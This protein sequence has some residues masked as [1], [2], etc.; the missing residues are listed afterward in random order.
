[1]A[2]GDGRTLEM[3]TSMPEQMFSAP[4]QHMSLLQLDATLLIQ[5][6]LFLILLF[7]LDRILFKPILQSLRLR[8]EKVDGRKAEAIA[9]RAEAEELV[10]R[11]RSTL[12]E[13]RR[14]AS[15]IRDE[16]IAQGK[17][18]E[19]RL[20]DEVRQ[21]ARRELETAEQ[22]QEL[23]VAQAR[24]QI[25]LQV[26]GLAASIVRRVLQM[27]VL[28]LLLGA[29]S[30]AVAPRT[31]ADR[32]VPPAAAAEPAPAEVEPPA[33]H[34]A[35][36]DPAKAAAAATPQ[37]CWLDTESA[38]LGG[39]LL[40][41]VLLLWLL[42][43]F[44]RRPVRQMLTA[45][46]ERVVADLAEAAR[47]REEAVDLL[48]M[49]RAKLE[50]LEEERRD[51]LESFRRQGE[52]ERRRLIDE[53]EQQAER[54]RRDTVALI[55]QEAARARQKI[56]LELIDEALALAEK[57][58]QQQVSSEDDARQMDSFLELLSGS[59]REPSSPPPMVQL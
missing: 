49:A 25:P 10:S 18:H 41:F 48:A 56:Q 53:A 26:P 8:T 35:G 40:N 43:R 23:A 15:A 42:V 27:G 21:L 13:A 30:L 59:P 6:G 38:Q 20:I 29:A 46:R 54:I 32:L 28:L 3:T 50:G 52:L 51:L 2:I 57:Q 12:E 45:R 11:Y 34:G 47:L 22:Q 58:V 33:D 5:M 55:E 36:A 24:R 31:L 19:Q 16:L 1:M 9:L 44:G 4:L 37:G 17:E 14:E 7:V 39:W